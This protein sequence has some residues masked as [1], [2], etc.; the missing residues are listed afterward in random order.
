MKTDKSNQC[1]A[2]TKEG[3]CSIYEKRPES[4]RLFE[5]NSKCCEA[6][7]ISLK[8]EHVCKDCPITLRLKAN[9]DEV[10]GKWQKE[11]VNK[12]VQEIGIEHLKSMQ[13]LGL[14]CEE[15]QKAY[16]Q[17]YDKGYSDHVVLTK[18]ENMH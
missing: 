11:F 10:R 4:C 14:V 8:N 1:I 5:I 16:M 3:K 6:F 17:G 7:K 13:V 15:R 9:F 12:L 2:L 18:E